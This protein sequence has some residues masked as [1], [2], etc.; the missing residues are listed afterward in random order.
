MARKFQLC[1][2]RSVTEQYTPQQ[3]SDIDVSLHAVTCITTSQTMQVQISINGPDFLAL[4]DSGS[5]HN[6]IESNTTT[7]LQLNRV[8]AP[9]STTVAVANGDQISNVGIYHDLE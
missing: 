3:P 2:A 8:E 6:Y 5:T 7:N 4:L 1:N 9:S